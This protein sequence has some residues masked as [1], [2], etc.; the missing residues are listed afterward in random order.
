MWYDKRQ[1][2]RNGWRV[3]ESR[4]F[5][6]AL[7]GGAIGVFIGMRLFRH[8]TKH[9]SFQIGVPLLLLL[10]IVTVTILSNMK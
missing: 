6:T 9:W 1:A 7:F 4:L 8:K 2:K 3:P 5:L 10:N